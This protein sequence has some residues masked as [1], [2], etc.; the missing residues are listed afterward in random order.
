LR[1]LAQSIDFLAALVPHAASSAGAALTANILAVDDELISRRAV[2]Y[3]LEKVGLICVSLQDPATALQMIAENSFDLIIL[4][5][6][7]PGADGFEVCRE[8]RLSARNARTPVI[9]VSSL[10]DW[11]SRVASITSGGEDLIAK[12]FLFIELGLKTLLHLLR[13]EIQRAKPAG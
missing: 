8:A 3:A 5:I 4:D 7:M 2:T 11:E 9:Y 12:P 13:G 10:T 6:D 1:T